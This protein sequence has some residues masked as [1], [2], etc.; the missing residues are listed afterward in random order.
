MG[1]KCAILWGFVGFVVLLFGILT[2][3]V[4]NIILHQEMRK[5]LPLVEGTA[6]YKLWRDVPV[7]MQMQLWVFDVVNAEE[8]MEHGVKPYVIEK[9]PY[10]YR[11]RKK[12]ENITF[13]ANSTVTFRQHSW[14]YFDRE[15]SVGDENDTFTTINNILLGAAYMTRFEYPIIK[16]MTKLLLEILGG[17]L[18]EKYTVRD[19][20]W[21]YEDPLLKIIKDDILGALNLSYTLDDHFG[22]FYKWNGSDDGQ[23]T[24]FTGAEDLTRLSKVDTYN[25]LND[26]PFWSTPYARMLNGTDGTFFPPFLDKQKPLFF[27]SPEACRTLH[28]DFDRENIV[29]DIGTYRYTF[30]TSLLESGTVNPDNVGFCTPNAHFCMPSGLLNVSGCRDA[31]S[32]IMSYPHFLGGD[33]EVIN[34]VSGLH[35]D[36]MHHAS[37]LDLEPTSGVPME[38]AIRLQIGVYVSN[39]SKIR[40]L[41][42]TTSYFHPIFWFNESTL[43]TDGL[44][45]QLRTELVEVVQAVSVL[46]YVLPCVGAVLVVISVVYTLYR[47][48]RQRKLRNQSLE[49]TGQPKPESD[50]REDDPL[51]VT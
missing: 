44:A 14:Y 3:T 24:V 7:P 27:Y 50:S 49:N 48:K 9:G 17:N 38:V 19:I 21:G 31:S 37:F 36:P 5:M 30:P 28:M 8:V 41:E 46:H 25:G 6:T 12:K 26:A 42:H 11:L 29:K 13:H 20:I 18:Y 22:F 33:P 16:E 1:Q 39:F 15:M 47:R 35:P 43:I 2:P 45:S 32:A 23:F 4:F 10:S 51:L 40:Q 34:G